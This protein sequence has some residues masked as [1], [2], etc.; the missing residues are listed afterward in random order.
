MP[1]RVQMSRQRPWRVEHPDAVIIARPSKW[2]NPV[3]I[4]GAE[5]NLTVSVNGFPAWEDKFTTM[6]QAR[7]HAVR[8]YRW[9]LLN[10]P[11]VI[12]YTPGEVRAVLA[13]KDLACWCKT[14][15]PCHGDVLLSIAAGKEI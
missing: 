7:S 10:H 5:P 8:A 6:A 2:G 1:K 13:G 4:E 3:K 15:D 11:N 14:T 9:Q 12:G